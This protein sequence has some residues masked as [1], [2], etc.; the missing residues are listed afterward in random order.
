[1]RNNVGQQPAKLFSM[2]ETWIC[3]RDDFV[4]QIILRKKKRSTF[5]SQT[6]TPVE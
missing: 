6:T 1:M 5:H 2:L 3:I 4:V